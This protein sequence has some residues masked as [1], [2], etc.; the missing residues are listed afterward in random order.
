MVICKD[1][2]L[3]NLVVR[4]KIT[5]EDPYIVMVKASAFAIAAVEQNAAE[6]PSRAVRDFLIKSNL[7]T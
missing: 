6:V 2:R 4:D 1:G 3:Y 7:E 5:V